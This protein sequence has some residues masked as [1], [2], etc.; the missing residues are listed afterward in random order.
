MLAYYDVHIF[1]RFCEEVLI[2][3]ISERTSTQRSEQVKFQI[4]DDANTLKENY[5]HNDNNSGNQD[6]EN[7]KPPDLE[8]NPCV[9]DNH[10]T[11]SSVH[12]DNIHLEECNIKEKEMNELSPVRNEKV[13]GKEDDVNGKT[14]FGTK[15]GNLTKDT[16]LG[17]SFEYQQ[18]NGNTQQ[19]Q[20]NCTLNLNLESLNCPN[21]NIDNNLIGNTLV[22]TN[23]LNE[24]TSSN[25]KSTDV[26]N[27]FDTSNMVVND[28][29]SGD[30]SNKELGLHKLNDSKNV[31]LLNPDL[32]QSEFSLG[33]INIL[34]NP[35]F[36]NCMDSSSIETSPVNVFVDS[37]LNALPPTRNVKSNNNA[38]LAQLK[39]YGSDEEE[40][41]DEASNVVIL[42]YRED[43]N[44]VKESDEGSD[45]DSSSTS[46]VSKTISETER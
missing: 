19:F 38:S 6:L 36:D 25:V 22:R 30:S 21:I 35:K 45:S 9:S 12:H 16:S 31:Q 37:S 2:C 43:K 3:A 46:S 26:L 32:K 15:C 23:T 7:V 11:I 40:S 28:D 8:S 10:E 39:A 1:Y 34:S 29:H 13:I 18:N 44:Q 20:D 4:M 42:E 27:Y 17:A 14:Y 41:A 5:Y 33:N 24:C